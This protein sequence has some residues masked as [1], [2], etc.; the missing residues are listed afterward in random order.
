MKKRLFFVGR[1]HPINGLPY[2]TEAMRIINQKYPKTKLL[3]VGDGKAR[4]KVEDYSWEN[5]AE[6]MEKVYLDLIGE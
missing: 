5:I 3:I 4:K 1:L 2:L 6:E